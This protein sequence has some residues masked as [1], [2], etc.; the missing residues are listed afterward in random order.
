LQFVLL[1]RCR[2]ARTERAATV[3]RDL[4]GEKQFLQPFRKLTDTEIINDTAPAIETALARRLGLG[5]G[6]PSMKERVELSGGRLEI[7]STRHS[8]TI[9]VTIALEKERI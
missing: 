8:T 4:R 9:L 1:L 7:R 3:V 5:V 6:I 2:A